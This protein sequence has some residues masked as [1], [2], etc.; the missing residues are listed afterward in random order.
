M[1]PMIK[2]TDAATRARF[3]AALDVERVPITSRMA[4]MLNLEDHGRRRCWFVDLE[5]LSEDQLQAC[6]ETLAAEKSARPQEVHLQFL[7]RGWPIRCEIGEL[8]A[9]EEE[10]ST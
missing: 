6:A 5:R 7:N 10:E 3:A 9:D 1:G 8:I 4:V 2:I